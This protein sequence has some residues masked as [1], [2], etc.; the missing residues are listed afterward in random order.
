MDAASSG[1]SGP[2]IGDDLIAC[3]HCGAANGPNRTHC[4]LC[5]EQLRRA[6][7]Y[8]TQA[9]VAPVSSFSL[10]SLFLVITLISVCLG[11]ITL[12]P[13]LS[14]PLVIIVTLAL[15][16]TFAATARHKSV[17]ERPDALQKVGSFAVSTG[18]VLLI[19]VSSVIAF[20]I[21]CWSL[22]GLGM[23]AGGS[24]AIIFLSIG[25]GVLAAII[26]AVWL[27]RKTWPK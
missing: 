7:G 5:H 6:I 12:A 11:V 14:I 15:I 9:P 23:A 25:G 17:G 24:E 4:W 8:V 22:C 16:R 26:C 27:L 3:G 10:A 2:P 21:A 13:G 20:N 1:S 19:G 18:I